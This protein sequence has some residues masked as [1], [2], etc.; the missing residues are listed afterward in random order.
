VFNDT[1][2]PCSFSALADLRVMSLFNL[3]LTGI[4]PPS[5]PLCL[6]ALSQMRVLDASHNSITSLPRSLLSWHE[7]RAVDLGNNAIQSELEADALMVFPYIEFLNIVSSQAAAHSARSS[8]DLGSQ[9]TAC[10]C[11]VCL[12]CVLFAVLQENNLITADLSS[13]DFTVMTSLQFLYA[14]SNLLRGA[15]QPN[16]FDHMQK[17]QHLDLSNNQITG[18]LPLFAHTGNNMQHLD[19]REPP[20]TQHFAFHLLHFTL[21]RVLLLFLRSPV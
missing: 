7:L 19:V 2:I 1:T 5:S 11:D 8:S 6:S 15:L 14:G 17:L 18:R 21:T 12:F 10:L 3:G 13:F 9:L 16:A 20:H 4:E